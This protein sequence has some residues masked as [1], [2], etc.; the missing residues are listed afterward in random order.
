MAVSLSGI[1][2][3]TVGLPVVL[4]TMPALAKPGFSMMRKKVVQLHT[5]QPAIVRLSDTTVAFVGGATDREY[6]PVEA[7]LLETL[8]TELLKNEKTLVK[9]NSPA[10]AAWTVSLKVTGYSVPPPQQRTEGS[11]VTATH[12]T[13]WTGSLN[14]AYQV[15]DHE[16]KVHDAQNISSDYDRDSNGSGAAG[17]LHLPPIGLGRHTSS[18]SEPKGK[19]PKT[20]EDVKQILISDVVAKI[21]ANLG[22][23]TRT[24][25]VLVAT[26]DDHLNQAAV[27]MDDRLWSRALD[28]LDSTPAFPKPD[29]ESYRQYDL[30]LVYEALSYDSKDARDQRQ[31]IYKAA[32]YYDKALELNPRE[33]YFVDSVARSKDA[34]SRYKALD[35][36]MA[37]AKKPKGKELESHG[38]PTAQRTIAKDPQ[39]SSAPASVFTAKDAI[40]L[41][42]AQ[43]PE[44]QIIEMIQKSP[45]QFDPLDKNTVMAMAKAKLPRAIQNELRKK[46]GVAPLGVSTPSSRPASAARKSALPSQQ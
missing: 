45:V 19:D 41:Y 4:L 23:T 8:Q 9:K 5:R 39:P 15:L 3:L 17:V 2:A 6:A 1:R 10:E 21:G 43:V 37:A 32:E 46:V 35:D 25:D 29:E 34:I 24:L 38:T 16:G 42:T 36:E 13:R 12:Y 40:D 22:N 28:L 33:R 11:G 14:V 30:G 31:N 26:G 44:E 18:S 20:A 27:F 7:S